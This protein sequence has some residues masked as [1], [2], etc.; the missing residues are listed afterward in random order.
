[1][2]SFSQDI[3]FASC[4]GQLPPPDLPASFISQLQNS[5]TGQFSSILGGCAG[6]AF[7]DNVARGYVTVDTVN[8]CTLRF[9]GDAGY[10]VAGGLGD[11]TNQNVLWGDYFYVNPDENFAQGETL[12][13]IEASATNPEHSAAGEY[14]FYGRY[15]AWT[16]ADNREPLS[17]EFATRFING[18]I[19]TG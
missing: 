8:N 15:L 14:T 19:F 17:T 12:V 18:G 9:P 6:R 7:G 2:G 13:H 5:R 1:K 11:A 3:N 10:F 16:A 4:S